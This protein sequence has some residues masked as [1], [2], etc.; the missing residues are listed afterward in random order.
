MTDYLFSGVFVRHPGLRVAY[1]EGQMGWIPFVL[2][3]ADDVW[4]EHRGWAG[5]SDLVTEP[6]STYFRTNVYACFFRD[7]FGV[8]SLDRIGVDNV[9][10]ETDYP[11]TDSTWP[12]TKK[13]AT[14]MLAPLPDDV[15]HKI[16]RG[17]AIRL[18]GLDGL[19]P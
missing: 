8:A 4:T 17:N 6:P 14:D 19:E 3:R 18:F 11:H 2:Q 10:F 9:T 1:S 5:V 15:V 7:D 13:V 12:H 16:L